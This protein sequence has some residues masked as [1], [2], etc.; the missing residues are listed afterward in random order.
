M[1]AMVLTDLLQ[2]EVQE[3][4]DP[5]ISAPTDLLLK[6][7]SIG[8]CGSDIHYYKTGRIGDQIVEFPF[9]VGHECSASVVE[10]GSAVTDYKVGDRV[11]VDPAVSCYDCDQCRKGRFHT[12][13]NLTFLG[14]PGQM[15]G[16]LSEYYVMPAKSCL[17]MPANMDFETA[18]LIEPLTIGYYA[19][20]LSGLDSSAK[21]GILGL[22]PIGLSVQIALRAM[23]VT[24][25]YVTDPLAHRLDL[26]LANGAT[27]GWDPFAVDAAAAVAD[28]EPLLLDVV[29]ECCGKQEALDDATGMLTNGG[30]IM[31]IGIP[32]VERLSYDPHTLR[33][34][35]ACLQ[36]VRRQNECVQAT[37]DMV[38]GLEF[39]PKFMITHRFDFADTKKAFDLVGDYA[40]GGRVATG[41]GRGCRRCCCHGSGCRC[42]LG[43]FF[44]TPIDT[45]KCQGCEHYCYETDFH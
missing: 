45:N 12:C 21:V 32:D 36:N 1:K 9:I 7:E 5:K 15:D 17:P 35:E 40:D 28:A 27:A 26:S 41:H 6:L 4:P 23:G 18:A 30:K 31:T 43:C 42:G 16:C 33:R 25:I 11:V 24:D 39:D 29:F 13:R 14:C 2:M 38:A 22:G 20:K 10:V 44:G 19:V 34:K 3:R 37:V 8:V